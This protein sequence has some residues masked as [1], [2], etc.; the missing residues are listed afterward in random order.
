MKAIQRVLNKMPQRKV[1][2]AI[3]DKYIDTL[4]S[5]E[6][7]PSKFLSELENIKSLV[8]Q[9]IEKHGDLL[10]EVQNVF[11]TLN[12]LGLNDEAN[13]LEFTLNDVQNDFDELVY[14]KETLDKII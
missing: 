12:E 7:N 6:N 9:G 14:I 11:K 10:E 3:R 2:L 5:I 1:E 4:K 13:D 8:I